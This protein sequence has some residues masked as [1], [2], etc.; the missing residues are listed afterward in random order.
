MEIWNEIFEWGVILISGATVVFAL[1]AV[2][3]LVFDGF[4]D[5]LSSLFRK[6]QHK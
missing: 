3:S 5:K 2:L 1:L 6:R 4:L